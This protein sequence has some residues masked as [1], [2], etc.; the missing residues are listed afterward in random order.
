MYVNVFGM[1]GYV[2]DF[3]Q[4]GAKKECLCDLAAG[5]DLDL[6]IPTVQSSRYRVSLLSF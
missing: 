3:E 5:D 1:L 4:R 6:R 2:P